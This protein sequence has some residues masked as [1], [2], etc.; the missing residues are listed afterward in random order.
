M[1]YDTISNCTETELLHRYFS[2]FL[3]IDESLE[4]NL[5]FCRTHID[6][7]FSSSNLELQTEMKLKLLPSLLT[8]L[9]TYLITYWLTYFI[10]API[11]SKFAGLK[12]HKCMSSSSICYTTWDKKSYHGCKK[13]MLQSEIKQFYYP[14]SEDSL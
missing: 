6:G 9:I 7:Y 13:S 8:Y 12:Y 10:R 1:S 14:R 4:Q 3:T 5:Y 2:I 11:L